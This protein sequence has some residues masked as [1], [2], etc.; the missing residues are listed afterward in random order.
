[1]ASSGPNY[2]GT[3]A[4]AASAPYIDENWLNLA[5]IQAADINRA[6]ITAATFDS[7]DYSYLITASNFGFAIPAGATIDGIVVEVNRVYANGTVADGKVALYNPVT[8]TESNNKASAS[9]WGTTW[10]SV[11]TY[12]GAADLWGI[13]W[14][15][16]AINNTGFAIRFA[17]AATGAN[18]DAYIDYIRVTVYYTA[19]VNGS[20]AVTLAA[21][22]GSGTG[23]VEVQGSLSGTLEAVTLSGAGKVEVQGALAQTLA[24]ATLSATGTVGEAGVN[25]S[26]S[27]TLE[28]ATLAAS[29]QVE[30]Q[31]ALAQALGNVTLSATAEVLAAGSLAVTLAGMSL[32]GT[33]TVIDE[34][35]IP[36][37]LRPRTRELTLFP[38]PGDLTLESRDRQLTL[39]SEA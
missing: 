3:V 16:E 29:G 39:L 9:T 1:L 14:T 19:G 13:A 15:A 20:L 36:L 23:T 6:S 21:L 32:A 8:T 4:S 38:R 25:G 30:V 26:L 24:E 34:T 27:Q 28:N 37:T 10:P 31:G 22:I 5:N 17:A 18:A 33:G 35:T 7:P 12:G 2:A 11:A